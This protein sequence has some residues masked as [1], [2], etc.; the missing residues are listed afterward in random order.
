MT[1]WKPSLQDGRISILAKVA[2]PV[3]LFFVVV[4]IIPLVAC[5][6]ADQKPPE[7]IDG[8]SEIITVVAT[9]TILGDVVS[10]LGGDD[11]TLTI[12]LPPGVDPHGYEPTPQ[13]IALVS[14]AQVVFAVGNGLEEFLDNLIESAGAGERIVYVSEALELLTFEDEHEE[15]QI[16]DSDP[17]TWTDPNNVISWAE[18]IDE[19]LERLDPARSESYQYNLQDYVSQLEELDYW[20]L[21][22][23]QKVPE[24]Q[25][26]LV[27]DHLTLGYFAQRYGFEQIGTVI[28]GY[29]SMA[30]P[31][32]QELAELEDLIRG[33]DVRAIFVGKSVNPDLAQRVAEDTGIQL[34]FIYTGSLSEPGGE[35]D[36]YLKYMRYN[37]NAI[38]DALK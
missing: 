15:H 5:Y 25:R 8:D 9:T 38:I 7:V 29:S 24:N 20:I 30:K 2:F 4:A 22:E 23:T 16:S 36:S 17:H 33:F 37:T 6:G 11:I 1:E 28:P 34:V 32:A 3:W 26:M 19:V 13:D 27:S 14:E 21:M 31:S 35:A 12:L 18:K 10:K